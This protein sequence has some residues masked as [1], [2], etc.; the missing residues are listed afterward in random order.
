MV[1]AMGSNNNKQI[2][3]AEFNVLSMDGRERETK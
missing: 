2:S 1:G 3:V